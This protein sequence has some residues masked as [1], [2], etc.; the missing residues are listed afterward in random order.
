MA[1]H[2]TTEVADDVDTDTNTATFDVDESVAA[3]VFSHVNQRP[4]RPRV[5][6][7]GVEKSRHE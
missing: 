7:S 2:G 4:P 1:P 3:T 6:F 5:C